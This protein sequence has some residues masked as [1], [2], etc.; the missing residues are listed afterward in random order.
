M[1]NTKT[2]SHQAFLLGDLFK[3]KGLS[4]CLGA[5]VLSGLGRAGSAQ[6]P[7][8]DL[9]FFE[10]KIRPVLM[11]RCY[12][13]H[14]TKAE[15][16]KGS[17]YLDSREAFLKGGD[18]G[19][20]LVAGNPKKSLLIKAVRWVDDDLKMPPKKKLTDEQI[21]DLETWIQKGAAWPANESKAAA[22]KPRKQ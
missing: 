6:E 7:S 9:E 16:L 8:R 17:L 18:T 2:P 19:P 21:A 22:A 11:G 15:K 1:L 10:K 5:L 12:S 20:A 13:C 3:E 4:L 14:S